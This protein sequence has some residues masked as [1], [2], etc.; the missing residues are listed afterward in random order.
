[1]RK[2]IFAVALLTAVPLAGTTI[3]CNS[4]WWQNFQDNPIQQVQSFEQM[5]QVVLNNVQVAWAFVQPFL[6]QASAAQITQQ[7]QNAVFAVNHAL[8]VL[9]DAVQ[10]EL[11]V[12]NPSPDFSKLMVAVTDAISQVIA[13]I[14]QYK[15]S[16]PADAGAV[17]VPTLDGGVAAAK[18]ALTVPG[19]EDARSS[20]T[21]LKHYP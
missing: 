6:P 10:T 17:P 13:I 12:R 19:L 21:A 11:S 7:Y 2:T 4:V 3:A 8:V 14:D 5:V 1:M 9:N 18:S 20:L 16:V 15:S